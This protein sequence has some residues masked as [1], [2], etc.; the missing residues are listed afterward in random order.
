MI[1]TGTMDRSRWRG[2]A[3]ILLA[4]LIAVGPLLVRGAPRGSDFDFH[5][6]SWLDAERDITMGALHPHWADSPNLGAGEP[7]FVFY[8]PLTWAAGAI[9]GIILPWPAVPIVL[10]FL[11]LA[12]TGLANR[13]LGREVMEEGPATL[14][15]C[16]AI[17]F[18]YALF[19]AYRRAAYGEL[20]AGIWIP[21]ILLLMLRRRN[22]EGGWLRDA[23]DGSA[24]PLALAVAATALSNG[25]ALI[26]AL[27]L[28]AAIALVLSVVERT[29][30]PVLRAGK[31]TVLGL[32]AAAIYL[33]PAV[34]ERG[35]MNLH[36]AI[37]AEQYVIENSWF[38]AH[39]SEP[40]LYGHD[41]ML[42]QVSWVGAA[43]LAATL[44]GALIARKHG[45]LPAAKNWRV[46][47]VLIPVVVLL[48]QL[49]ITEP[50]WAHLP[51]LRIL[52]FPWRWYLVL[53]A[54]MAILA[55]LAFWSNNARRR[56]LVVAAFASL[57]VGIS[58]WT[59][60]FG[61]RNGKIAEINMMQAFYDG[62]GTKGMFEYAPPVANFLMVERSIP[63]ACLLQDDSDAVQSGLA[64][65]AWNGNP[66]ECRDK[67][68]AVMLQPEH[69]EWRGVADRAGTLVLRLRSFPAWAV[70]VN[71]HPVDAVA[72]H[73]YGL[74]A[75]PVP[76]GN[77]DV[78]VD[79]K[80]TE[81]VVVGRWVTLVSLFLLA[82]LAVMEQRL[83]PAEAG[84][85][86][87]VPV[88]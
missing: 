57:F 42:R 2:P 19:C 30:A 72:E 58:V 39:H 87:P 79:W 88:N 37:T 66:V 84:A 69:K 38:F 18:G 85:V 35:W 80:T 26:M 20:A 13:A 32:G 67:I 54:P 76:Q 22:P 61:F 64:V 31:A 62:E 1:R 48:L 46:L 65:P 70:T 24:A 47:L 10:L 51:A 8:P 40:K 43:M 21:L 44:V 3:I 53:E 4:A 27:Y 81:D 68:A 11:M 59:S 12:G 15:G 63:S 29:A 14:A 45:R 56:K 73:W 36:Y 25:P 9:L 6:T 28:L 34:W 50:V 78:H 75:V 77:V 41:V 86:Q 74:V 52:Q 55:A 60:V 17:F 7:R 82:G 5:F 83:R 33:I 23:F 16:V 49:P 71:G